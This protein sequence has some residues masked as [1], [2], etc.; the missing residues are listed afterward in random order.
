M[1]VT[2]SPTVALRGEGARGKD[3]QVEIG[4]RERTGELLASPGIVEP[5]GGAAK[6]GEL[7]TNAGTLLIRSAACCKFRTPDIDDKHCAT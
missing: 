5:N 3:G 4:D 6:K 2:T 1:I 7:E